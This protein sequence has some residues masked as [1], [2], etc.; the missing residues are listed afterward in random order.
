LRAGAAGTFATSLPHLL[1]FCGDT[2]NNSDLDLMRLTP[3]VAL[4]TLVLPAFAIPVSAQDNLVGRVVAGAQ[5]APGAEAATVDL[6]ARSHKQ[7][8]AVDANGNAPGPAV[9]GAYRPLVV[10]HA[11]ANHVPVA[12][13]HR[14]IMRESRYNPRAVSKGNFGIMQIRLGTARAL[15]YRGTAQGLL[16]ADTNMTYAVRY[17]AGAYK[18]ANGN[19]DQAVRL[20]ARGYY[21]DAK[22]RG[23]NA[24][25]LATPPAAA[26]AAQAQAQAADVAPAAAAVAETPTE[27]KPAG[28]YPPPDRFAMY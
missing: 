24:Y 1:C 2:P 28:L 6:S 8:V 18:V 16:D 4:A 25:A 14:V 9:G 12:L 11:A 20:Y 21:Y 27:A 15:G 19:H 7:R 17:L 26:M 5:L 13:V 10:K 3:A 23:L 22:R